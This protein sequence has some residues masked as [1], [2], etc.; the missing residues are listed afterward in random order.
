MNNFK[1][2]TIHVM[3]YCMHDGRRRNPCG[4]IINDPDDLIGSWR[5]DHVQLCA[6]T[7]AALSHMDNGIILPSSTRKIER[8]KAIFDQCAH[9]RLVKPSCV[10]P[11]PVERTWCKHPWSNFRLLVVQVLNR[12]PGCIFVAY[13]NCGADESCVMVYHDHAVHH[14]CQ[15]LVTKPM[16][17]SGA[18]AG[19]LT[20]RS[21]LGGWRQRP[22]RA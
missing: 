9:P 8:A 22:R 21:W 17:A 1:W 12:L 3:S 19:S 2:K 4:G 7:A 16:Q 20:V 6:Q 14:I 10:T 18:A 5:P 13:R 15:G 11:L